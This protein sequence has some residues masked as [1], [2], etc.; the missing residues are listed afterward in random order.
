M[1]SVAEQNVAIVGS[2]LLG[3]A[4]AARLPKTGAKVTLFE[5]A[6]KIGGPAADPRAL[7]SFGQMLA[8]QGVEIRLNSPV[9]KVEKIGNGKLRI[10]VKPSRRRNDPKPPQRTKYAVVNTSVAI[11][12]G[13]SGGFLTEPDLQ[14]NG[15]ID[16]PRHGL[17]DTFDSVI[18]TCA[19]NIAAKL[20]PQLTLTEKQKV[21]SPAKTS[22]DGLYIVNSSQINGVLDL[23]E[24]VQLADRFLAE[25]F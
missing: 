1:I 17:T 14:T 22:V 6:D 3:T 15:V 5:S 2:G 12:R 25:I 4:L 11:V 18:I 10:T 9:Q 23:N 20:A 24:I 21:M 13:F 8:Y 7:E 19:S 16:F